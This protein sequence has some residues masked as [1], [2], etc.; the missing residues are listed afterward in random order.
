MISDD[1]SQMI[2]RAMLFG[3]AIT[4]CVAE[5]GCSIRISR[6]QRSIPALLWAVTLLERTLPELL[7]F[8]FT[9]SQNVSVVAAT[10]YHQILRPF[11][12]RWYE[13][14]HRTMPSINFSDDCIAWWM[15]GSIT[16]FEDR[17]IKLNCANLCDRQIRNICDDT[18]LCKFKP[19]VESHGIVL[20]DAAQAKVWLGSRV[21][22]SIW[23]LPHAN[24]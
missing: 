9:V 15:T 11:Y 2:D 20:E 22:D 21:P 19:V 7:T 24:S 1:L 14:G 17:M 13:S 10:K 18:V 12:R 8:S 4:P 23:R 16:P 6:S 3:A 5:R